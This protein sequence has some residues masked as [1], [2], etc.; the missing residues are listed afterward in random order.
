[1]RSGR[2]SLSTWAKVRGANY[3]LPVRLKPDSDYA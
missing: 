2:S 3:R 1:M